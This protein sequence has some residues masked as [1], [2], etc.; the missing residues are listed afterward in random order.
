LDFANN[1][2][3]N[4]GTGNDRLIGRAALHTVD[5]ALTQVLAIE[6]VG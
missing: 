5:N 1:L 2:S 3:I 4:G 6:S